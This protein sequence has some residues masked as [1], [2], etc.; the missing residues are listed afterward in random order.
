MKDLKVTAF[1]APVS[2]RDAHCCTCYLAL[3][4]LSEALCGHDLLE[5]PSPPPIRRKSLSLG[6]SFPHSSPKLARGHQ[7][8]SSR[9][10]S[11]TAADDSSLEARAWN[12]CHTRQQIN[13]SPLAGNLHCRQTTRRCFID[14]SL[15]AYL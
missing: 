14:V 4:V 11:M 1:S 7:R 10:G 6:A 3:R 15:S 8:S 2:Q 5:A 9:K 13:H 12:C